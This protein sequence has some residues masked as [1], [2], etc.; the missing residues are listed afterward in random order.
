MRVKQRLTEH[1]GASWSNTTLS[2]REHLEP[3]SSSLSTP[4]LTAST[5]S[6]RQTHP[7]HVGIKSIRARAAQELASPLQNTPQITEAASTLFWNKKLGSS[8]IPFQVKAEKPNNLKRNFINDTTLHPV[9]ALKTSL[10][11]STLLKE[12]FFVVSKTKG[13]SSEWI[14]W[15]YCCSWNLLCSYSDACLRN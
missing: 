15:G 1:L 13:I 11:P 8:T 14:K 3:A 7:W 9:S 5:G 2:W 4:L 12:F 6:Y 10:L